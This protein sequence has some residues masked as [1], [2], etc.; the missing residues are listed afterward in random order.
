M[1]LCDHVP[2]FAIIVSDDNIDE[3]YGINVQFEES[4]EEVPYQLVTLS[5]HFVVVHRLPVVFRLLALTLV[6][7]FCRMKRTCMGRYV[8]VRMRKRRMKE[9]KLLWRVHSMLT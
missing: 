6:R 3:T 9:R 1:L 2:L 4:E 7:Y 8:K 5:L